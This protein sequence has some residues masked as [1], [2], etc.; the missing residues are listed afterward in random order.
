MS[1]FVR[2]Q[3]DDAR[4]TRHGNKQS[5]PLPNNEVKEKRSKEEQ[6]KYSEFVSE[7]HRMYGSVN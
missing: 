5:N 3:L 1:L 7:R 4:T 2:F 6:R